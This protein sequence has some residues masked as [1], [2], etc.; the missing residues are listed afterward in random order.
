MII[1][2]LHC[3]LRQKEFEDMMSVVKSW[4]TEYGDRPVKRVAGKIEND[5]LGVQKF[6]AVVSGAE[7]ASWK[8]V[9]N[10]VVFPQYMRTPCK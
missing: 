10:E 6:I 4:E 8:R 3:V 1:L 7:S 9:K 5:Q 2:N